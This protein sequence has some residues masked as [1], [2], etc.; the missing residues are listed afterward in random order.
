MMGATMQEFIPDEKRVGQGQVRI[1]GCQEQVHRLLVHSHANTDGLW[2]CHDLR[3]GK[4]VILDAD[5]LRGMPL[6]HH[7]PEI[8]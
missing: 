3:T 8:C 1:C 2:I 5:V 4:G 7:D 6:V